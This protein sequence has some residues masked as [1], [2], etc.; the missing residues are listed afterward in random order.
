MIR[1]AAA[2]GVAWSPVRR[3]LASVFDI[4]GQRVDGSLS[5]CDSGTDR[6]RAVVVMRPL[7]FRCPTVQDDW[8]S[9][10]CRF[11]GEFAAASL[12]LTGNATLR[13]ISPWRFRGEFAA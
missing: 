11:R 8:T 5:A 10:A 1:R 3:A 2:S 13:S 7:A 6:E 12:K 4:V 9:R